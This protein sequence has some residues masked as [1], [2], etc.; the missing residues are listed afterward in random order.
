MADTLA[1]TIAT[2]STVTSLGYARYAVASAAVISGSV[3]LPAIATVV[4][5][6]LFGIGVKRL[7]RA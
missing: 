3:A 1:G 6:G 5:I 2:F 4:A 7:T